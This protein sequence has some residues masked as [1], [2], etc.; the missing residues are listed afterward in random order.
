MPEHNLD[1]VHSAA[2]H[3]AA[4]LNDVCF[5]VKT[6]D[7]ADQ[8]LGGLRNSLLRNVIQQHRGKRRVRQKEHGEYRDARGRAV[9]F[10]VVRKRAHESPRLRG[11]RCAR[12]RRACG[13]GELRSKRGLGRRS[14]KLRAG[15]CIGRP[16]A[17]K[18]QGARSEP[19]QRDSFHG[20]TVSVT[21]ARCA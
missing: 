19:E 2:P 3:L 18:Q 16:R 12:H 17:A 20:C 10:R 9:R 13:S 4:D 15:N 21:H 11:N 7:E 1:A 5:V 14:R 6:R 8:Q